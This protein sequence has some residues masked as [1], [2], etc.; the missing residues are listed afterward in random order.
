MIT[1]I[2][3]IPTYDCKLQLVI[4]DDARETINKLH[5][6]HNIKMIYKDPLEGMM[7]TVAMDVY[8]LIIDKSY[9]TY[10][11]I[12]HESFHATMAITADRNIFEEESRA[13][14][15][16]WIGQQIYKFLESRNIKIN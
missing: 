4:S 10:N 16:G 9:V 14:L 8:H 11:T 13:W 5:K 15:A 1:K 3:K 2:F 7:F 6:K 12:N